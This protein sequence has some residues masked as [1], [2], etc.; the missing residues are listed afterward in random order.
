M[1]I[2]FG[3]KTVQRPLAGRHATC[4]RCGQ[5]AHHALAERATRLT[6]FFVPVFTTSRSYRI[7]CSNCGTV[8]TLTRRQKNSLAA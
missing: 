5:F 8:N 1:F 6:L 4:Q 3:F 7:T 2:L